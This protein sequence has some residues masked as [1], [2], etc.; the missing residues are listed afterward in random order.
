[1]G[2]SLSKSKKASLLDHLMVAEEWLGRVLRILGILMLPQV[3]LELLGIVFHAVDKLMMIYIY[4]YCF[5]DRL[6]ILLETSVIIGRR[7]WAS[8]I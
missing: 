5:V 1:V 8:L 6:Q 7:T 3:L 4:I 2:E